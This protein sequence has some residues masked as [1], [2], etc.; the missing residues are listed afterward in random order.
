MLR[1]LIIPLIIRTI[2]LDRTGQDAPDEAPDLSSADATGRDVLDA[3]HQATDLAV[4]GSNPSRRAPKPQLSGPV[5]GPLLVSSRRT[6]TKLRPHWRALVDGLRP[7][8]TTNGHSPHTG[9]C[10]ASQ[11]C[12]A[13]AAA[14]RRGRSK[15]RRAAFAVATRWSAE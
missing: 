12:P 15:S 3:E 10:L 5:M 2:R 1:G 14:R 6:A 9:P 11:P 7:P 8:A 4:G 13:V